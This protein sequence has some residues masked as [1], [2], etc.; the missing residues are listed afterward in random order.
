MVRFVGMAFKFPSTVEDAV[1]DCVFR[2]S[3]G[4]AARGPM[5]RVVKQVE[6]TWQLNRYLVPI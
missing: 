3:E 6:R 4:G 5:V 2:E 1:S